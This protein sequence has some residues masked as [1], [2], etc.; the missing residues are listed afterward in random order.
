MWRE[1][2]D[3]ML[4]NQP[5]KLLRLFREGTLKGY[6]DGKTSAAMASLVELQQKGLP[7]EEAE[8]LVRSNLISPPGAPSPGRTKEPGIGPED[9]RKILKWANTQSLPGDL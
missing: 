4:E 8:D 6:L 1:H 5:Q 7:P 9:E 2:L 3:W